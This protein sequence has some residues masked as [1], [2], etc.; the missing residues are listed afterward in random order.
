MDITITYHVNQP[1]TDMPRSV[2]ITTLYTGTDSEMNEI[3]KWC[4]KNI[5]YML[6]ESGL[7][8]LP[9]EVSPDTLAD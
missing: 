2:T 5:G 3:E 4:E 8:V 7:E 6:K 1:S 9:D